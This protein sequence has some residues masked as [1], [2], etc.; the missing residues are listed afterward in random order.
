[1]RLL[2]DDSFATSHFTA[3]VRSG[4]VASP[5]GLTIDLVPGLS[6]AELSAGDAALAPSSALAALSA[7]H[8]VLR[9]AAVVAEAVGAIAMRTPVRPDDIERSPVRLLGV[10]GVAEYLARAV[11][12][13]FYGITPSSW[14]RGDDA[15]ETALAQ[16]VIVEGA[17]ALRE[18]EGGFSE[19]LVR[20]WF[21]LT[22]QPVVTH[23]TLLPREFPPF[24]RRAIATYLGAINAAGA[25]HRGE[26]LPAL[27]DRES[28]PRDRSSAFWAAQRRSLTPADERALLDLLRG[29][30]GGKS[31]SFLASVQFTSESEPI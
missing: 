2:I 15:P 11:L 30:I 23:V 5:A 26:W 16:V 31:G 28:V 20:A 6:A 22:A 24:E 14:V 13:S 29:G 9:N 25:R 1:M 10:S 4:W 19:D 27:A 7:S 3:P 8:V 21:I 18:A 12:T 17:E